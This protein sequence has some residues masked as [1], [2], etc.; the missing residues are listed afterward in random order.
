MEAT[1]IFNKSVD[2][3]EV[4]LLHKVEK[5]GTEQK[6][7]CYNRISPIHPKEDAIH[8]IMLLALGTMAM[9]YLY[10]AS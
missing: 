1:K 6:K 4:I 3:L 5:K 8:T 2:K 9:N 10:Q 7:K